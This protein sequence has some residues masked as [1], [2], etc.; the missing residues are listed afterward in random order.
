MNA[1]VDANGIRLHYALDGDEAGVPLV[2]VNSLGSDL[3]LWDY[4][5]PHLDRRWRVIRYDQRGQGLSDTPPAPYQLH[6]HAGDLAG[7]LEHLG[8]QQP[9]LFG[10]SVGGLI[11]MDYA[12]RQPGNVRALVLSDTAARI[13]TTASWSDRIEGIRARGLAA[14]AEGILSRWVTPPFAGRLPGEYA[15]LEQMLLRSPVAGYLATCEVL[16]DSDL[17]D[18]LK[19]LTMP[20]LALCGAEDL[21]TPPSQMREL[22]AALPQARF[23]VIASAAHLPFVEQ[24]QA[25]AAALDSFFRTLPMADAYNEGRYEQGMQVRRA[26]LGGDYVDRA[27]ANPA[28]L[29]ADFQRFI[30]QTVWGDVWTRPGLERKTRHMLTIAMLAA[31]GREHELATHIRATRNT[32]VSADELKE[33]LLQ[34]AVYAGVPA[35]NSAFAIAKRVLSE[36]AAEGQA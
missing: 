23:E 1:V 5:L 33:I 30:T 24:P 20:A 18:A 14:M 27:T 9:I 31:L 32:G 36:P 25:V 10:L 7:L 16:R 4:L 11:V 13:G 6:D 19:Q 34:V 22:A 15:S 28:G 2:L 26:V 17:G 8:V 35:A 3:H 29:D 12:R 21:S